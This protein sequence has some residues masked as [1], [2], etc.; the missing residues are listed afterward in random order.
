MIDSRNLG[1]LSGNLVADPEKVTENVVKFRVAVDFAGNDRNDKDNRTGFFGFTYFLNDD[2]MNTKFVKSQ[3]EAGN[4][5]KGSSVSVAYRLQ[6][7]RW[8]KDDQKMSAIELIAESINYSGSKRDTQSGDSEPSQ[9]A[10]ST[11][12]QQAASSPGSFIPPEF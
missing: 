2:N 6:H 8:Q 9:K 3:I 11:S 7:S 10:A 4:L 1:V 12:T 5:K